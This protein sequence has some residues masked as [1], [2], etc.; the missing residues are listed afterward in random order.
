MDVGGENVTI[1]DECLIQSLLDAQCYT[2]AITE[3]VFFVL[4]IAIHLREKTLVG[5]TERPSTGKFRWLIRQ[6]KYGLWCC[7]KNIDLWFRSVTWNFLFSLS[8][9]VICFSFVLLAINKCFC[10]IWTQCFLQNF[11]SLLMDFLYF[12]G[13]VESL[14][15]FFHFYGSWKYL[16]NWCLTVKYLWTLMI[17]YFNIWWYRNVFDPRQMQISVQGSGVYINRERGYR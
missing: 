3:F 13:W 14:E 8:V 1:L 16:P 15:C 10:L 12:F 17:Y 6:L 7:R 4:K 11:G 9:C 2:N 5:W